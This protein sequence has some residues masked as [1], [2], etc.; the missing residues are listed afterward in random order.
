MSK[1][2]DKIYYGVLDNG[3]QCVNTVQTSTTPDAYIRKNTLL[4]W[5]ATCMA[6]FGDDL[7]RTN[8]ELIKY[9]I[10]TAISSFQELIDKINS[11]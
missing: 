7:N 1:A 4:D 9:M 5:M 10:A 8:D 11:L 2:P 3:F 6:E